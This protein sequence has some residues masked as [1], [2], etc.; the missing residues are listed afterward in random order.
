MTTPLTELQSMLL[1]LLSKKRVIDS[2]DIARYDATDWEILC[3]M[4]RQHRLGPLLHWRLTHEHTGITVPAAVRTEWA[5]SFEA[6]TLLALVRRRDLMI[7]HQILATAGIRHTALKGAY[8][9]FDAYPHPALRPLSDLDILVPA[10]RALEAYQALI[11]RGCSRVERYAVDPKLWLATRKHLPP[12]K[13]PSGTTLVEL[14]TRLVRPDMVRTGSVSSPLDA[15][16]WRRLIPGIPVDQEFL[17]S[18]DMLLHLIVHAAYNHV[19]TN[20]PLLFSDIGYLLAGRTIDWPLFWELAR[21]GGWSRGCLLVLHMAERYTDI[22]AIDY[23]PAPQVEDRE[24][25]DA[26]IASASLLTLRH[27][28]GNDANLAVELMQASSFGAKL[29]VFLGRALPPRSVIAER[30]VASNRFPLNYLPYL[31]LW[32][33]LAAKRVP[34]YVASRRSIRAAPDARRLTQLE[35]WLRSTDDENGKGVPTPLQYAGE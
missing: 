30:Y 9:A 6:K 29:R 18:T 8:L 16:L 12:L 10:E 7:C 33:R 15:T 28:K 13:S 2:A 20:G 5:A 23:S 35:Q 34:E 1:D 21:M 32:G 26:Q 19:F 11:D 25:L 24:A 14:H 3:V 22:P 4:A 31:A 17:S 27:P